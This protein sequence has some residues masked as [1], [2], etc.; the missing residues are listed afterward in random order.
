VEMLASR[1]EKGLQGKNMVQG[2]VFADLLI[3][4]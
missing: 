1:G 2:A 3:S 4:S